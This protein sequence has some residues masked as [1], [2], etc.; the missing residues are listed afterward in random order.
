[1]QQLNFKIFFLI[2]WVISKKAMVLLLLHH[3]LYIIYIKASLT[4][5]YL[6]KTSTSPFSL[7]EWKISLKAERPLKIITIVGALPHSFSTII[8]TNL[9]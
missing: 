7:N 1:M 6:T 3:I 8:S 9:H 2:E 5:Y 4:K